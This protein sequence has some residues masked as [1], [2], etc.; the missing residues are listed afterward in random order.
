MKPVAPR[1]GRPVL[2][3]AG[4]Y[5]GTVVGAGF[6]SGQEILRF[7]T[8]YGSL[9]TAGM[10]ISV[11]LLGLY[12]VAVLRLG[13]RLGAQSHRELLRAVGGPWLGRLADWVISGFLFAGTGVMIA[14]SGAI[15]REQLALPL[16]LGSAVMT[17]AAIVTVAGGLRGVVRAISLVAPVL[18]LMAVAVGLWSLASAAGGSA[19]GGG[20]AAASDTVLAAPLAWPVAALGEQAAAPHWLLAALLYASYNL[21]LAMPILAPL[22]AVLPGARLHWWGGLLGGFGLGAAGLAIHLAMVEQPYAVLGFEVPMLSLVRALSPLMTKLYTAIL[23]AEVYTTAV[24][25]LYSVSARLARERSP[26]FRPVVLAVAVAALV[27]SRVG[28]ADLV[29]T[30]YPLVGYLGLIVLVAVPRYWLSGGRPG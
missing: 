12:G 7:F 23:W 18:V 22:G 3:I 9:G 4:T 30:L 21:L 2:Q 17:V 6:A 26:A 8:L 25:G 16:W 19:I 5:I 29:G 15:F 28:F 11:A 24:A 27:V 1:S 13:E 10:L 14:G 20:S